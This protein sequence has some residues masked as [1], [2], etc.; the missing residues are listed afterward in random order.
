MSIGLMDHQYEA[1]KK[2]IWKIVLCIG[3]V[4]CGIG[5]IV[6]AILSVPAD[7]AEE[8]ERMRQLTDFSNKCFAVRGRSYYNPAT[9]EYE[10]YNGP[11]LTFAKRILEAKK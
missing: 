1:G 2:E 5:L 6:I 11:Q 9:K 3:A 7:T 10:C 4:I 8:K